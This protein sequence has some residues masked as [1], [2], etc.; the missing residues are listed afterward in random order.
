MGNLT[1]KDAAG[2]AQLDRDPG[3]NV[4]DLRRFFDPSPYLTPHSDLVALMVLEH[5]T[6]VHNLITRA[7]HET[8]K[9]LHDEQ[10]LNRELKR[11]PGFRSESTTSRI[12]SVAE[13]LLR[14]LLFSVAA[15]LEGPVRGTS[16][17]RR[18]VRP[19]R[20]A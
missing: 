8:R 14:G 7:N 9:A 15:P 13:P 2:A 4:K 5:Q 10:L 11:G 17:L 20:A 1:V 18:R 6:S 16:G 12:R 3:A 19:R